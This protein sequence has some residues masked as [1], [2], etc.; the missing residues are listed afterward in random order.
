MKLDDVVDIVLPQ[1][2]EDNSVCNYDIDFD[3]DIVYEDNDIMVINKP[4]GVVLHS[5]PSVKEA[6]WWI[7]WNLKI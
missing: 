3:I 4:S 6:H 2:I 5:A 1:P 7:G